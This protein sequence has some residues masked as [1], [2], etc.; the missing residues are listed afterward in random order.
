MRKD[1]IALQVY[2]IREHAQ[3]AP[4]LERSLAR[5]SEIGY[6]AVQISGVGPI[7]P[8]EIRRI[9]DAAGLAICATHEPAKAIIESPESVV[10]RLQILGCR[11]TCYPYPHLAFDS[12]DAVRRLADGLNRAGAVLKA[13]GQTLSYHNHALEFQRLGD[14]T[15][16]EILYEHTDRELVQAEIDTYWVQAGGGDPVDWCRRLPGRLPLL[17]LKD[18]TVLKNEPEMAALGQ[19][20]LNFPASIEAA[21][22]SGCEWFIVEQDKGFD[23]PFRAIATSLRYLER[24][25]S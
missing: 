12:L 8:R 24:L 18:Y 3:T 15:V 19:G 11:H 22:G 21:D 6:R 23:D 9:C 5:V 16:L 14:Q 13:A 4:D 7:E 25:A 17:H 20:N 10:E 2:T 1:Q